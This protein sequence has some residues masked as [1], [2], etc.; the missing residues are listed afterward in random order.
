M[1][2]RSRRRCASGHAA[3]RTFKMP[4]MFFW[5]SCSCVAKFCGFSVCMPMMLCASVSPRA[6]R[7][8]KPTRIESAPES[9]ADAV[10]FAILNELFLISVESTF[11]WGA[12]GV[13]GKG[14][15]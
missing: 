9:S 6:T 1:R 7:D 14:S 5:S 10:N 8:T 12:R 15:V 11:A 13:T 4:H 3:L 2:S